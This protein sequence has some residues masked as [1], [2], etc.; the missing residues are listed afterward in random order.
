[1][2]STGGRPRIDRVTATPAALAALARLRERRGAVL[3]YQSGGCCDGSLPVCL[4][5]GDL[6]IGDGDVLLGLVGGCPVYIDN[7]QY[8]VWKHTQL[9]ID[10]GEGEPEGFSLPAGDGRQF[11]TRSRVFSPAELASL[12]ETGASCRFTEGEPSS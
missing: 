11:V 10:V 7:R 9:I 3:L 8:A 1:M 2:A 12:Q 5:Q 4:E 6:R